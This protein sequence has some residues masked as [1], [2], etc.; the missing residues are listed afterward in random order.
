MSSVARLERG[1]EGRG[2]EGEL[3]MA[4]NHA[5]IIKEVSITR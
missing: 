3:Q 5:V 4:D 1:W 2:G